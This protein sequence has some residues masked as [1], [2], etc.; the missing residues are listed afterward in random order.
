MGDY[1]MEHKM[2]DK[3]VLEVQTLRIPEG[4]PEWV[5]QMFPPLIRSIYDSFNGVVQGM[6]LDYDHKFKEL[7]SQVDE[8][9]KQNETTKKDMSDLRSSVSDKDYVI[10]N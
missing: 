4:S 3:Y 6:V 8:L 1:T 10:D 9:S 2:A 7:Q 5:A